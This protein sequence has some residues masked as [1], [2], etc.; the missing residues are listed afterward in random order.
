MAYQYA[1]KAL[2]PAEEE[3]ARLADETKR[4]QECVA[5]LAEF[6]KLALGHR[7]HI[8]RALLVHDKDKKTLAD[9]ISTA[10]EYIKTESLVKNVLQGK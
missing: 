1:T 3:K 4:V 6:E 9:I 10:R 8:V 5:I 2:T 7:A